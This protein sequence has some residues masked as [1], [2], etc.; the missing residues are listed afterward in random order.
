MEPLKADGHTLIDVCAAPNNFQRLLV[1]KA[2]P[3]A[4]G[5]RQSREVV[6][7]D[8]WRWPKRLARAEARDYV[9]DEVKAH[10][11]RMKRIALR[12]LKGLDTSK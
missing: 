5:Y 1:N 3:H 9:P 10:I 11:D 2:K 7:G 12:A 4:L 8:L 6:W